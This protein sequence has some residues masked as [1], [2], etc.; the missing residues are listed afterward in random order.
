[1]E[2]HGMQPFECCASFSAHRMALFLANGQIP[3]KCEGVS[4]RKP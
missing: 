1:M 2:D 4:E 3:Y